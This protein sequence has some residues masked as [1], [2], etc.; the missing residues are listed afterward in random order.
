MHVNSCY[1]SQNKLIKII[2]RTSQEEEN[3]KS[4]KICCMPVLVWRHF[5]TSVWDQSNLLLV[6]R[7]RYLIDGR[8]LLRD[9]FGNFFTWGERYYFRM[10]GAHEV[11]VR[12]D[13]NRGC[14]IS[15]EVTL[16]GGGDTLTLKV[17]SHPHEEGKPKLSCVSYEVT[18]CGAGNTLTLKVTSH[19][20]EVGKIK[21]SLWGDFVWWRGHFEAETPQSHLTSMQ[22]ES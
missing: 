21:L 18:L 13:A 6:A 1:F 9:F 8:A 3:D 16:C 10:E 20:C 14:R 17:T 11:Y 15:H 5:P 19:A 12:W 4:W 2:V 22:G 7:K